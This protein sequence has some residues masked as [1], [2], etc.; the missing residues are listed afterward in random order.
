ML[1]PRL[2]PSISVLFNPQLRPKTQDLDAV[3]THLHMLLAEANTLRNTICPIDSL[4]DE[5]LAEIFHLYLLK[6]GPYTRTWAKIM[7]ICRRWYRVCRGAS[8]L[9]TYIDIGDQRGKDILYARA[10]LE[11]CSRRE[12]NIQCHISPDGIPVFTTFFLNTYLKRPWQIG[13][14]DVHS[15]P[16][17]VSKILDNIKSL[18][19]CQY[20]KISTG[21]RTGNEESIPTIPDA[22][23]DSPSLRALSLKMVHFNY[24]LVKGL[25]RLSLD[26]TGSAILI[27]DVLGI[28][29][30]SPALEC[31]SL[32]GVQSTVNDVI[33]PISGLPNVALEH[34]QKFKC[35]GFSDVIEMLWRQ[36]AVPP[37]TKLY[38]TLVGD[39][40]TAEHLKSFALLIRQ[41]FQR[42]GVPTLRSLSLQN[43]YE[44]SLM[45][46]ADTHEAFPEGWKPMTHFRLTMYPRTQAVL[47]QAAGKILHALPL[48]DIFLDVVDSLSRQDFTPKTW[49]SFLSNLPSTI[50]TIRIGVNEVMVDLLD[51]VMKILREGKRGIWGKRRRQARRL[52]YEPPVHLSKLILVADRELLRDSYSEIDGDEQKRRYNA[53]HD[54]LVEYRNLDKPYKPLDGL[55]NYVDIT[56]ARHGYTHAYT[57]QERLCPL[58]KTLRVNN[59]V[60]DPIQVEKRQR[61]YAKQI[62]RWKRK[63][64]WDWIDVSTVGFEEDELS[65][66]SDVTSS[67]ATVAENVEAPVGDDHQAEMN[68]QSGVEEG[69]NVDYA[70]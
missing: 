8:Q 14:L 38:F 67:I 69:D 68:E 41:H 47:R 40:Y 27:S 25:T 57:E 50:H 15:N 20:L 7:F 49:N 4:P 19:Q 35:Q 51:A 6:I 22:Y 9:W 59:T 28:L 3:I 44:G 39:F 43:T 48:D 30:R 46:L 1:T 31:L 55:F 52:S 21:F 2:P 10:Q 33:E 64:G 16:D 70:A 23:L 36:I 29:Q 12:L 37:T 24:S 34:I 60:Y 11:L 62:Y 42:E 56:E 53:L 61:K 54:F 66:D 26:K 58:A 13:S 18:P 17:T 5:I 63:Y 32:R 45:I 65:E